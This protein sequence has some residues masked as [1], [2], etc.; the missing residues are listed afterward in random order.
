MPERKR[1]W[2]AF[3]ILGL[4]ATTALV[5]SADA[6]ARQR[7]REEITRSAVVAAQLHA[8]VLRS[9][10]DRHRSLPFVLVEDAEVQAALTTRDPERLAALSR[11][12]EVLNEHTRASVIYVLDDDGVALAASNWRLPTSFVGTDYGFR[13]Y[14]Q[15]AIRDGVAEYFALGAVSGRPGLFLARR[16]VTASGVRG[17]IVVKVEFDELEAEWARSGEPAFVVDPNGV[18]L[19]TGIP[20]WRFGVVGPMTPER[21][22]TLAQRFQM[23][24]DSLVSLP[25]SP[26]RADGEVTVRLPGASADRRYIES[27][28]GTTSSGW[29]LHLLESIDPLMPNSVTTA[30]TLTLSTCLGVLALLGGLAWW[31]QRARARLA[32]REAAHAELELR[33]SERTAQLR[34][35]NDRLHVE[36]DE[37]KRAEA[38]LHLLRDELVQA[39]K[40]AVL[41]Q[42]AAGV[43][44]EIN[45]PIAAIR[46]YADN[47]ALLLDRG[48]FDTV[49][50]NMSMIAR[51][52]TRV[53]M[54]TDELRA[55]SRKST[56]EITPVELEGPI[57]GALLL[58]APQGRRRGVTWIRE[59]ATEGVRVLADPTRLEQVL[60]NLFQN[61]LEALEG[62]TSPAV[63]V[64]VQ[65]GRK[66]VSLT[67]ADNGPGVPAS[68]K[69]QLFT[70]FVTSKA[71]GVGLGLVISRDIVTG[72]DG[73]LSL[74]ET[75]AGA[76]FVITLRRAT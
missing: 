1:F 60:M 62:A 18:V 27:T 21:R 69:G 26:T 13:P 56:G 59:G 71:N 17:V 2:A 45:Q 48:R 42:V 68:L 29:T 76:A 4:L 50:D 6:V 72:W 37:R 74:I 15:N 66:T 73:D 24:E 63:I 14:F 38:N 75:G 33:V 40:L 11:K 46:T 36:I 25:I 20:A 10:L 3:A 9:E 61:A 35:S 7:A 64:R 23:G 30:R 32:A 44:H 43:A 52:T 22:Q 16:I 41:G 51:M 58:L 12:L 65:A 8:A 5:W 47:T 28:I 19:V 55:F 39:N 57:V 34:A 70:P 31:R 49:R 67:I 53:G 54:I